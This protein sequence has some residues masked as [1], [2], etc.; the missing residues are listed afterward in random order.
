MPNML[1]AIVYEDGKRIDD[2]LAGF[3]ADLRRQGWRVGGLLQSGEAEARG[4]VFLRDI[5][6]ERSLSLMQDLGKG[7]EACRLDLAGLAQASGLLRETIARRPQLI[8][9]N[10]FGHAEASG[11]GLRDEIGAAA[12]S[13]APVLIAVST[14]RL[15]PW[16][17][18]QHGLF[19]TLACERRALDAWWADIAAALTT[20]AAGDLSSARLDAE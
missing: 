13:G 5:E 20:T 6:S 18:Y 4:D 15:E 10:R 19:A 11:A 16:R 3:V 17:D 2:I 14:K 7:S 9:V 12:Q 8:V 1:A